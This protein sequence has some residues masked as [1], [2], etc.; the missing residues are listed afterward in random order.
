MIAANSGNYDNSDSLQ[1]GNYSSIITLITMITIFGAGIVAN[2]YLKINK[3]QGVTY[4]P[5]SG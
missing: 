2:I 1:H 5:I 4:T 3:I